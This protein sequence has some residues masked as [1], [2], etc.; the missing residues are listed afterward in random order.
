MV[1]PMNENVPYTDSSQNKPI[2]RIPP[3]IWWVFVIVAVVEIIS[4]LWF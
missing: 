1:E 4:F 2:F 3:W